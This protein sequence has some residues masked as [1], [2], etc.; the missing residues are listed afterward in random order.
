MFHVGATDFDVEQLDLKFLVE[1]CSDARLSSLS[2]YPPAPDI[3]VDAQST[4][5]PFFRFGFYSFQGL[6]N[7]LRWGGFIGPHDVTLHVTAQILAEIF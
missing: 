7:D 1:V 2:R 4:F 3:V 6:Q 5:T